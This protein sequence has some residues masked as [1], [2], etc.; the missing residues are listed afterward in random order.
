M[1][2]EEWWQQRFGDQIF[3]DNRLCAAGWIKDAWQEATRQERERC[4]EMV[5]EWREMLKMTNDGS[6]PPKV[7]HVLQL[8]LELLED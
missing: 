1:A 3:A 6:L 2:F 8:V 7:F 5:R 4:I